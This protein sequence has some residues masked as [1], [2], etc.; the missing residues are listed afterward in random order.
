MERFRHN[1]RSDWFFAFLDRFPTPASIVALS[2]EAFVEAAWSV[3][4]R[5]VSKARLLGDIYETAK[6]SIGLPIPVDA[7]AIRMF[8]L[9]IAEARSLIRQRDEIEAMADQLLAASQDYA[10][11]RQIPGI[12]PINALAILA[13][14][15]DLRRFGHH[16]QFLK[17]C[18]LD[19]ATQQSGPYLVSYH[20]LL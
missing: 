8:R 19:L 1:S 7:P 17:F 18:G 5:K 13:E 16:R 12:G 14:A 3:V 11:L 9:V 10:R 4:G 6:T 2:K 20:L 15:G